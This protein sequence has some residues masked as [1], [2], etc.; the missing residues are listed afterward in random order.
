MGYPLKSAVDSEALRSKVS[1]HVSP[2][3]PQ[4]PKGSVIP[5]GCCAKR[6]ATRRR[7]Q[8]QGLRA[9]S[10]QNADICEG[11]ET[12]RAPEGS[13]SPVGCCAQR[14]ATRRCEQIQGLRA[15]SAQNAD[16]CERQGVRVI[17]QPGRPLHPALCRQTEGAACQPRPSSNHV[18]GAKNVSPMRVR[19]MYKPSPAVP[20]SHAPSSSGQVLCMSGDAYMGRPRHTSR[21]IF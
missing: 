16:I 21:R 1:L 6:K 5:V 14:K 8:I 17:E 11:S 20:T 18:C 2:A 10:A 4:A 15:T 19:R 7:E 3:A 9:A 13:V 12:M